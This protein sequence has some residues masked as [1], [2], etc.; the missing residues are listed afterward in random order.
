MKIRTAIIAA[1]VAA[2]LAACSSSSASDDIAVAEEAVAQNDPARAREIADGLTRGK[3][4]SRLSINEL[5]RLSMIY[6]KLSD[7]SDEG[8]SVA[9]A[10]HCFREAFKLNADSARMFYSSVSV[11]EEKYVVMLSAIVRAIEQPEL[12]KIDDYEY[13]D[14]AFLVNDLPE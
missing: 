11:D 13:G 9:N 6:M 10:T 4:L 14:S 8:E 7:L 2:M 5:G 1:A 12:M 3:D